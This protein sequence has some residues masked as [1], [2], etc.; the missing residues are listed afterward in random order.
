MIEMYTKILLVVGE[1]FTF[2]EGCF[3]EVVYFQ[4]RKKKLKLKFAEN[5][6]ILF[7][8]IAQHSQFR[9]STYIQHISV[10]TE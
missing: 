5:H 7:Y 1:T 6:G 8:V 2:S 4:R 3:N 10:C 9:A